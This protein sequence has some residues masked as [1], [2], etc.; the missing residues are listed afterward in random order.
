MLSFVSMASQFVSQTLSLSTNNQ[1]NQ[2]PFA[3]QCRG[4]PPVLLVNT[5]QVYCEKHIWKRANP[6]ELMWFLYKSDKFTT[7]LVYSR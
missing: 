1:S 4:D 2:T 6:G 5:A 7:T 3:I